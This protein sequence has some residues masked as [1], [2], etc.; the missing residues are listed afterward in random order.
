MAKEAVEKIRCDACP[1]MCYIADGNSGACDRY[2]NHDGQI[3]RL[4]PLT[5]FD[6]RLAAG[7]TVKPFLGAGWDGGLG[8]E[9]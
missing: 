9:G 1:V 4:D 2:A 3:V 8:S 5:I 7:D 6:R